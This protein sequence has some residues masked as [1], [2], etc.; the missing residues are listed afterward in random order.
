M[1]IHH[2]PL[3]TAL[4][5]FSHCK[6]SPTLFHKQLACHESTVALVGC[7]CCFMFWC[8]SHSVTL[9]ETLPQQQLGLDYDRVGSWLPPCGYLKGMHWCVLGLHRRSVLHD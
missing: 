1:D 2:R 9:R 8:F 6:S 5:D 4:E 7:Q 3:L